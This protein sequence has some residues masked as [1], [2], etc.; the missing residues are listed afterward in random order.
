V[1]WCVDVPL[2]KDDACIFDLRVPEHLHLERERGLVFWVKMGDGGVRNIGRCRG[3]FLRDPFPHD[4]CVRDPF[5]R[6]P[7][8]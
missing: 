7:Y 5:P 6:G 2:G 1:Q 4:P 3:P 8:W